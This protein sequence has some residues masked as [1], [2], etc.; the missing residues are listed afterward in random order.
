MTIAS[1]SPNTTN[2]H[3]QD[4]TRPLILVVDDQPANIQILYALLMA[5]YDVCMALGG[6]DAL[7]VCAGSRPDLILLDVV[8]PGIDG[9]A[10]C[11]R[12]KADPSMSDIPVI[13]VTGHLDHEQE[14][15]GFAVGG[16]DF[17]TKPF[18][19]SIVMARVRT[20]ITLK[21][22]ADL[23]RSLSFTDSLTNVANR[24]RFDQVLMGEAQRVRRNGGPLTLLMIDVDYFKRYNDR[25]GHQQGDA[26]LR[27]VAECLSN[28]VVRSHDLV[29]RYGGEE[30]A[31][32]LPETGL[33]GALDRAVAM[34]HSVRELAIA[35]D[36]SDCACVVTI[37]VGVALIDPSAT[38]GPAALVS[39]AD[40]QLYLAKAAG[41][42]RVSPVRGH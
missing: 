26:C 15:R 31:C 21:S 40:A 33:A 27:S 36:D 37:S 34:E 13:F 28:C 23:L 18:H 30:F 10:V 7:S 32:I 25:Y 16:V 3:G 2:D 4:R 24:R 5:E 19:A 35:H 11:S 41:R 8:M 9:Y 39:D 42:G 29:S 12:L 6:A 20:Q 22:Q 17:I 38:D 1:L 14:V